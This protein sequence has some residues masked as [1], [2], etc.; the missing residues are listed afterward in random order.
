MT[1]RQ[2]IDNY[3]ND[4]GDVYRCYPK[5]DPILPWNVAG[6]SEEE[7]Y[8]PD[9][10][11]ARLEKYLITYEAFEVKWRDVQNK[12]FTEKTIWDIIRYPFDGFQKTFS[13]KGFVGGSIFDRDSYRCLQQC[14]LS[15][16]EGDII[17]TG[18]VEGW[19]ILH[20][21]IPVGLTWEMIC[22]EGYALMSILN[23]EDGVFRVFGSQGNWGKICVNEVNILNGTISDYDILDIVGFADTE[24]LKKYE[25]LLP[26]DQIDPSVMD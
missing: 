4:Q 2:L 15:I 26:E 7:W 8:D 24:L 25:S 17:I 20:L 1:L 5:D 11:F 21:R 14:L 23:T 6:M 12:V 18:G 22:H 9:R 10:S 3:D 16:G 13:T 19:P